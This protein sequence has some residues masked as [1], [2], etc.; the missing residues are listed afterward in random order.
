MSIWEEL[1]LVHLA[2]SGSFYRGISYYENKTVVN[3]TF[4]GDGVYEGEVKGSQ[5]NVYKVLI[6][7]NHPRKSTCTCPFA[8]GRRVVCK[9]MV[10]LYFFYFPKQADA[11][12]AEWE[13]EERAKEEAYN[14][15]QVEYQ[16]E[17]QKEI[18]EITAY[19][20]SLSVEQVREKLIEALLEEFDREYP[21]DDYFD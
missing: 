8:K 16:K 13:A 14:E 9:H 1:K 10:A 19:V 18:E 15:W 11:V 4:S 17:R 12:I 6:D 5:G 7:I 3:G 21:D 2:S 20:N